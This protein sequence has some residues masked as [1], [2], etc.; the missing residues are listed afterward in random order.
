MATACE[1]KTSATKQ[2]KLPVNLLG[3]HK[4][5]T[6]PTR[7]KHKTAATK[8]FIFEYFPTR[9]SNDHHPPPLVFGQWRE[10]SA[11]AIETIDIYMSINKYNIHM[12]NQ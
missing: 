4:E 2:P 11:Y 9:G 12:P 6:P 7:L 8:H 5:T 10:M 1:T 3:F